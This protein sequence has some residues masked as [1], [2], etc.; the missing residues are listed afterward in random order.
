MLKLKGLTDQLERTLA[1]LS[2]IEKQTQQA[3]PGQSG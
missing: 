2:E 3:T 1:Y